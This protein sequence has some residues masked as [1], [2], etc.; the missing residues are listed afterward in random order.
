MKIKELAELSGVSVRTLHHYDAIGLLTPETD[1]V[2]GYRN[3]SD[4]DISRLQQILF[5]RQLN[6]KLR[7]IK[8]ILDSPHYIKREALQMQKDYYLKRTGKVRKYCKTDRQD[9]QR[10]KRR[11]NYDK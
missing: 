7:Q 6:F 9:N 3:Y 8:D 1:A 11:N 4:E 10:G 2:N 5:F